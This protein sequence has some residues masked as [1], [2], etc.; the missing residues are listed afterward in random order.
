MIWL[1]TKGGTFHRDA[2]VMI[3]Q[4]LHASGG[5]LNKSRKLAKYLRLRSACNLYE[6][7]LQLRA[8]TQIV[9]VCHRIGEQPFF[10]VRGA[11]GNVRCDDRNGIPKLGR[12]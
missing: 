1:L 9:I 6:S 5:F 3:R 8:V 2:L 4:R 7:S 10:V 12:E 11:A